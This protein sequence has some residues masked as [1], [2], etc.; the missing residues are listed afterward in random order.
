[1]DILLLNKKLIEITKKNDFL[2][3]FTFLMKEFF[4]LDN[5][6]ISFEFDEA[7]TQISY[8]DKF[9]RK[10]VYE[11]PQYS[12]N[13]KNGDL[14]IQKG[15]IKKALI[16]NN[17]II[18]SL[19]FYRKNIDKLE[20]IS[21]AF[22]LLFTYFER[23]YFMVICKFSNISSVAMDFLGSMSFP[24]VIMN[25]D[26]DFIVQNGSFTKLLS[27][28]YKTNTLEKFKKTVVNKNTVDEA[29]NEV[30]KNDF[31]SGVLWIKRIDGSIFPQ[32][33]TFFSSAKK[34]KEKYFFIFFSSL[35]IQNKVEKELDY[36]ANYDFLTTLP[37]RKGFNE[38]IQFLLDEQKPFFIALLDIDSFK[39]INEHYG[40]P[41]GD[42]LLIAFSKLLRQI[43]PKELYKCRLSGD[44]FIILF[45]GEVV[46]ERIN[47]ILEKLF[48]ELKKPL[49]I[50]NTQFPI[51]IS[52]GISSFPKYG[53]NL[54]SLMSSA[55]YA[56]DKAKE[57][58]GNSFVIYDEDLHR[59]HKKKTAIIQ[60]LKNSVENNEFL[61]YYQPIFDAKGRILRVEALIR[62]INKDGDMITPFFF[63]HIAEETG[64]ITKISKE[65]GR[66]VLNDLKKFK[67]EGFDH[68][69]ISVN[70]SLK[71]FEESYLNKESI[72]DIFCANK[73]ISKNITLEIT[74][75]LFMKE[76]IDYLKQLEQLRE[77]GFEIALDDF[78]TGYSSL[79][80][81]TKL[82]IDTIKIDKSF[83]LSLN[84]SKSSELVKIIIHMAKVLGLKV[85]AE[86]VEESF[87]FEFLKKLECEYFQGYYF[88]KPMCLKDTIDFLKVNKS[89]S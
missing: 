66:L 89:I 55:D 44:E 7:Y 16:S 13:L 50:N 87:H 57:C 38:K 51:T 74:E 88:S 72:L 20:N 23:Y 56:L 42:E 69:K 25:E 54:S 12:S 61:M 83:I 79:S 64:L 33:V 26:T 21:D 24:V 8:L 65:V 31:W 43:L 29:M 10:R 37:N 49:D 52:A 71:D 39:F 68:I 53:K 2:R 59:K 45:K 81:L 47:P 14:I 27:T 32:E 40:H 48:N 3:N 5:L 86:G 28:Y 82:P 34:N 76:R 30:I 73:N 1:M 15:H 9:E 60:N 6:K 78:G 11:I 4:S 17:Q 75:S 67:E 77:Y 35:T 63:I 22:E 18:G 84:D 41:F 70:V 62:W 46:E 85:I 80:Y 36:F 58:D 19:S